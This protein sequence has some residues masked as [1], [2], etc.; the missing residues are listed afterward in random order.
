VHLHPPLA[1]ILLDDAC[2]ELQGL[3]A[4]RFA[5]LVDFVQNEEQLIHKS[6]NIGQKLVFAVGERRVGR[7]D[8]N[9][10]IHVREIGIGHIRIVAVDGAGPRGIDDAHPALEIGGG[11]KDRNLLDPFLVARVF[12]FGDVGRQIGELHLLFSFIQ[13]LHLHPELRPIAQDRDHRGKRDN[14]RRQ[15]FFPQQGIDESRLTTL[16]LA[17]NDQIERPFRQLGSGFHQGLAG[18]LTNDLVQ[19]VNGPKQIVLYLP[20]IQHHCL[21]RILPGTRKPGARSPPEDFRPTGPCL[22]QKKDFYLGQEVEVI[23]PT[24]RAVQVNLITFVE[25]ACVSYMHG[26]DS[27]SMENTVK[28]DCTS[29]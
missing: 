18:F 12:P 1:D 20:V 7:G 24:V 9:R 16:E 11:V 3:L 6:S 25:S 13:V 23:I 28:L 21:H 10:G 5:D 27:K 4:V 22:R 17:Q 14:G 2:R 26:L 29:A 8:K 19:T 15:D